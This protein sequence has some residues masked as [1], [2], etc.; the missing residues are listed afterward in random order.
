[1]KDHK[2]PFTA[3]VDA[4]Q[5]SHAFTIP[6]GMEDFQA[7]Q[8]MYRASLEGGDQRVISAGL[9][10]FVMRELLTPLT[11]WDIDEGERLYAEFH[12]HFEP[13]FHKPYPWPKEAFQRVV[14]EFN[15]FL[16]IVVTGLK[17]GTAH[18]VGEPC[19]QVWTD[20][21]GMGELVGWVE[22]TILPYLWT[23]AT[24]ATRGR[25]RKEKFHK[26]YQRCY[27]ELSKPE[28]EQM[29]NTRFHDFG[30]RGGASSQFTGIA[31][32]YNWT[33]T[34]TMDSAYVARFLMNNGKSFG[35]CS[36][37]AAAH[38]SITPWNTEMEAYM[39]HIEH[40]KGGIFAIVADSYEYHKGVDML[41]TQADA[42]KLSNS[43]LVVR[44]DS[45]DPLECVL[46]ALEKLEEAFGV[47]YTNNDNSLKVINNA[48]VI[49]GDGVDDEAIFMIM[50]E[51]IKAGYSPINVAFGM[52]ENNHKAL[53][54]DL[55][56]CYKTCMVG[57]PKTVEGSH[58][59]TDI[60]EYK[61]VA[62]KSNSEFKMS[63]PELVMVNT[64]A[65]FGT[66]RVYPISVNQLKSG[67]TGDLVVH[68]DGRFTPE[69]GLALPRAEYDF[70]EIR[71]NANVTWDRLEK[72]PVGDTIAPEIRR[73]QKT[74]L[75]QY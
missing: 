36:I 46:Y 15:G 39:A 56:A 20:V 5:A 55:E 25:I 19:V 43:V 35:E 75:A 53:R 37:N 13:P 2:V 65:P 69:S 68:Y 30:R 66:P 54:S 23:M 31:H 21:K 64:K 40:G 7:S 42:I 6:K 57:V 67:D 8:A 27:P 70:S 22:S 14:D 17:D 50:E 9:K 41:C 4:Y 18:Y 11:Q 72:V 3:K 62:K 74:L 63:I 45:G 52:G 32:L 12:A 60:L 73:T 71:D 48:G 49:Q 28:I 44:P 33:G 47:T 10:N 16:P 24:V 34:D 38:R 58:G 26:V 1:M 51:V 59:S 29:I 61:Q